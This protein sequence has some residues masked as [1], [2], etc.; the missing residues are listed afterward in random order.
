MSD[1]EAGAI[2]RDLEECR[3]ALQGTDSTALRRAVEKLEKSAHRIGEVIY[4]DTG[5]RG[6]DD[7]L[8]S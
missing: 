6:G 4:S 2:T 7:D 8:G 5:A 1:A 3:R